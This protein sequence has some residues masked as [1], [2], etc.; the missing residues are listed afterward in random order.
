M[1]EI[2]GWQTGPGGR[3]TKDV[4]RLALAMTP[5]QAVIAAQ[6]NLATSTQNLSTQFDRLK[7]NLG[8]P[9]A[10]GAGA[11]AGAVTGPVKAAADASAHHPGASAAVDAGIGAAVVGLGVY[12]VKT[13]WGLG[14]SL[15]TR[16][17][18][19]TVEEIAQ[20]AKPAAGVAKV[21]GSLGGGIRGVGGALGAINYARF[22]ELASGIGLLTAEVAMA[23]DITKRALV[24]PKGT[25]MPWTPG[26]FGP[27][28]KGH[29]DPGTGYWIRDSSVFKPPPPALAQV[30][31][32]HTTTLDGKTIAKS[33]TK[34]L[35]NAMNGP[36]TGYSGFDGK[37]NYS[38]VSVPA[39]T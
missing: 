23:V 21:L 16:L 26:A 20:A 3:I 24:V 15:L 36:S 39:G 7:T 27:R 2:L 25:I 22:G 14:K 6:T 5:D 8:D 29:I 11:V 31:V 13:L 32:N 38:P 4:G 33:V 34:H 28:Q 10:K 19:G 1:A 9:M 12:G 30:T 18:S 17:T 35:V 37:M